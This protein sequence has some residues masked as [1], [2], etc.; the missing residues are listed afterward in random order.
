MAES[1]VPPQG[2]LG[3]LPRAA[4]LNWRPCPQAACE[5]EAQ[6]VWGPA[7]LSWGLVVAQLCPS[8]ALFTPA[9]L[10]CTLGQLQ[11]WHHGLSAPTAQVASLCPPAHGLRV[12]AVEMDLQT[13]PQ[14]QGGLRVTSG[15]SPVPLCPVCAQISTNAARRM[16]GATR[17]ATTSQAASTVPAT[18]ATHFPRT[19]GPAKVR[20]W[21]WTCR[22]SLAPLL[23][24][25]SP[26]SLLLPSFIW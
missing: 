17:Y 14:V 10:P 25:R 13:L 26:S 11:S 8:W 15:L 12:D 20:P 4:E 23:P 7:R 6:P 21:V 16:G 5:G 3:L 24:S 1:P 2:L 18:A 19:A 9:P 22:L